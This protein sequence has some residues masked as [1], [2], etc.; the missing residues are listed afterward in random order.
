MARKAKV[1]VAYARV[2]T[3][4]GRRIVIVSGS[5]YGVVHHYRG[6]DGKLAAACESADDAV[7]PGV[8]GAGHPA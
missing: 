4:P 6:I 7:L 5:P 1:L 8:T 3:T 2:R